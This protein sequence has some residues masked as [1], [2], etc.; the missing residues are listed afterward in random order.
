[1]PPG[2]RAVGP[3]RT[4]E[5]PKR[6]DFVREG[7]VVGRVLEP[8]QATALVTVAILVSEVN[9]DQVAVTAAALPHDTV[10]ARVDPHA[11]IGDGKRE[12]GEQEVHRV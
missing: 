4:V 7:G 1:M 8:E 11:R 6:S 3:K 10:V 2:R 12:F 9:D 5:T